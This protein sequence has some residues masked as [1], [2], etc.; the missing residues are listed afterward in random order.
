MGLLGFL[1]IVVDENNLEGVKYYFTHTAGVQ[2]WP[3][4]V[5]CI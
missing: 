2:G 1:G 5:Y 4:A 3:V